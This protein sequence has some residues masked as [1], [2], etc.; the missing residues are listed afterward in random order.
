[1]SAQPPA[2]RSRFLVLATL[3]AATG[4]AVLAPATA[5]ADTPG[6]GTPAPG[7]AKPLVATLVPNAGQGPLVRGGNGAELTMTVT[8]N[9]DEAQPFHPEVAVKPTGSNPR[10]WSWIDFSAKA[11]S[12]PAT[13]GI[14]HW[15]NDNEFSG[16]VVPE[17]RM[18]SVPFTVPARTTY[19]WAVSVKLKAALPVN[20]T[21]VKV[22]LLNDQDDSTNS[23]P[24]TLPVDAPT[25]A[26]L[27][28][29]ADYSGTVSY[30]QPFRTALNLTNN[31]GDIT[32][33]ITPTLRFDNA[34]G[35]NTFPFELDVLQDDKWVT[36]AG[37]N[38]TWKLPAVAGGLA[39]GASHQYE[40]RI[41]LTDPA[42]QGHYYS[43]WLSL[44]PDTDQG[45]VD[46]DSKS[47]LAVDG[48]P[49][50]TP[51][52]STSA[53]RPGPGAPTTAPTGT[54][55]TGSTPATAPTGT[56][57]TRV[58]AAALT[59]PVTGTL[60]STG[61]DESGAL[62][63]AGGALVLLGSCAV[64]FAKLRRTRPQD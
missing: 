51:A 55:T 40:V 37:T 59:S 26:L 7:G 38:N 58:A 21:A 10:S 64:L 22:E 36:V 41:S 24:M 6:T 62:L 30:K 14:A 48:T 12:A 19:S 17:N 47:L 2:R 53:P 39:K 32:S 60:A 42:A 16:V 23:A 11:I 63:G 8:N 50:P 9:S 54:P 34:S 44:L 31:G 43:E 33:A 25:G 5:F 3:V 61:A 49:L 35:Q 45:P 52:P 13:Y 1:M 27:Q 46:I 20:E 4:T 57:G 29:F 28:T 18:A 15:G 56:P